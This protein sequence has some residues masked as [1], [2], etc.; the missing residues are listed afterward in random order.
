M[1]DFDLVVDCKSGSQKALGNLFFRYENFLKKKYGTFHRRCPTV[2]MEFEDFRNEA[3]EWF[4]KAVN[5]TDP[6]KITCPEKWQ[7]MTPYMWYVNNMITSLVSKEQDT[8]SDVLLSTPVGKDMD[9]CTDM[10]ETLSLEGEFDST[11]EKFALQRTL[12]ERFLKSLTPKQKIIYEMYRKSPEYKK[13]KIIKGIAADLGCSRQWV[14]MCI[15]QARKK[16][17]KELGSLYY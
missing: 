3:Y 12:V 14:Y 9:N 10:F 13:S 4:I 11:T 2:T 15:A 17:L 8:C 7:F 1:T 6:A 16:F 5:Y